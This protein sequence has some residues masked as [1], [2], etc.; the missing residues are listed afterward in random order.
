MCK[1]E[2]NGNF[3]GEEFFIDLGVNDTKNYF[4]KLASFIINLMLIPHSNYFVERI[5]SHVSQ[6]KNDI[7]NNLDVIKVSSLIK[8]KY[9]YLNNKNIFEPTEDHYTLYKNFIKSS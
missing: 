2:N 4:K 6:I 9:L 3:N 8:I 1:Y 7:Q 5:F